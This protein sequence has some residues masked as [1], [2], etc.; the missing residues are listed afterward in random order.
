[1]FMRVD[2]LI[3]DTVCQPG[4]VRRC[5]ALLLYGCLPV[6][7]GFAA[8]T[9]ELHPPALGGCV[10]LGCLWSTTRC[11]RIS[12]YGGRGS[13]WDRYGLAHPSRPAAKL[14]ATAAIVLPIA[15]SGQAASGPF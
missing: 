8:R 1:M 6:C 14:G 5:G 10:G 3:P 7:A 13:R 2:R 4:C 11:S 15:K 12:G 9:D